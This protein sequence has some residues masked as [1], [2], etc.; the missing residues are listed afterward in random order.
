[1]TWGQFD[2]RLYILWLLKI[3]IY[4]PLYLGRYWYFFV[5]A[6][7]ANQASY[8]SALYTPQHQVNEKEHGQIQ[9]AQLDV[10]FHELKITEDLFYDFP[11][12]GD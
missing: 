11:I 3:C 6:A 5:S 10:V 7:I 9:A 4:F 12:T 1:M 8:F 2:I